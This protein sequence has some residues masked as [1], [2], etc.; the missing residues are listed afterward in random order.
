MPAYSSGAIRNLMNLLRTAAA[1]EAPPALG[2]VTLWTAALG[3]GLRAK[4]GVAWVS[5]A[6]AP[7]SEIAGVCTCTAGP[8]KASWGS[9]MRRS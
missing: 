6:N 9:N 5:G 3:E 8:L 4:Q 7:Q 2:V 1:R